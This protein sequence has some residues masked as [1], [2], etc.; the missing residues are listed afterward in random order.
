MI[1]AAVVLTLL[2]ADALTDLRSTLGQLTATTAVHGTFEVTSTDNNSESDK[3]TQGKA[4]VGFEAD[5][6]GLR[7]V[8][9]KGLLS[10]AVQEARAEATDPERDTPVISGASRV[11]P[12]HVA[13]LLD[14][15]SALNTQLLSA[16][17]TEARPST[18]Q[19]KPVHLLIMKVTPKL[20]KS[21]SKH[22]KKIEGTMSLWLG[23]DGVPLAAERTIYVKA[24]F[25]LMSFEQNEKDS[26]TFVRTG[27][28]LVA[29]RYEETQKSDGMGQHGT[30][31]VE[32][33]VRLE[34]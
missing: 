10:Q 17:L 6:S 29:T 5:G 9:P 34:P 33:T 30:S 3:A 4:S 31:R 14:A 26:W 1:L 24:S 8:Y 16:Q 2:P 19:G 13:D 15:A 7:I 20:S 22:V 11:R 12:L 28:R 21:S 25:M 32:Q 27:D 18:L 23:S